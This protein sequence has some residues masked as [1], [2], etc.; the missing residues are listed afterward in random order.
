MSRAAV[1][2][3][4]L[5]CPL[6]HD[7][8]EVFAALQ[9]GRTGLQP[10]APLAPL[11]GGDLA[12]RVEKP[13][14]R[15]WLRRRK[16]R[17]I[18]APACRVALAAAGPAWSGSTADPVEVGIFLGVGREPPDDGESED[19]LAASCRDG[20]LDEVLLRGPGRDRYPPLLPLKTLPNMA[21]AHISINLGI[22]GEN[23]AWAG[24]AAAGVRALVAG[25]Q[26]VAEGRCP[27][28]LAGGADSQID[29][30]SARDR[31]R[32]GHSGPPGEGAA[33]F[34]LAPLGTPGT[35]AELEL[36]PGAPRAP[37]WQGALGDLGAATGPVEL[38]L[39]I[40]GR[41]PGQVCLA[42]PGEAPIGLRVHFPGPC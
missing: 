19:A 29:L 1:V 28:V 31:L 6:G 37:R 38:A 11:V 10:H 4:G 16:D 35:L 32:L 27:E 39:L 18:M 34:R 25:V 21:L 26:A 8:A 36:C 14:L 41:Q 3:L 40:A 2:G 33:V 15:P 17:K 30:G 13:A 24:E 20:R 9:Q 7:P 12:G 42:D 22:M 5:S 23:G